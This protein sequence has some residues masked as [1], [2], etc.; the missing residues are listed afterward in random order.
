MHRIRSAFF[1]FSIT[2]EML[3]AQPASLSLSSLLRRYPSQPQPHTSQ[4]CHRESVQSLRWCTCVRATLY[5]T[6]TSNQTNIFRERALQCVR[7]LMFTQVKFKQVLSYLP[8]CSETKDFFRILF[9]HSHSAPTFVF[10]TC[11][12][13]LF[14]FFISYFVSF[15]SPPRHMLAY[16]L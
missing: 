12:R 1:D 8:K 9:L 6:D 15:P 3:N 16:S 11:A 13:I 7:V 14:Y 4:A 2:T 5:G 10:D